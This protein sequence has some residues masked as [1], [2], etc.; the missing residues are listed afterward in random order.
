MEPTGLTEVTELKVRAFCGRRPV[1]D[2]EF[3]DIWEQ[4]KEIVRLDDD[5]AEK[6]LLLTRPPTILVHYEEIPGWWQCVNDDADPPRR[7]G[8]HH[9][10]EEEAEAYRDGWYDGWADV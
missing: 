7:M 5:I 10:T 8:P 2:A 4:A 1:T 3:Q 9:K 6:T